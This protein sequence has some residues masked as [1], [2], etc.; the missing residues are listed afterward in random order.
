MNY[1][2]GHVSETEAFFGERNSLSIEVECTK[3]HVNVCV[4]SGAD[5]GF[6][7]GDIH[8]TFIKL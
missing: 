3:I 7:K 2:H 5:A 1:T 8:N 4:C 6:V